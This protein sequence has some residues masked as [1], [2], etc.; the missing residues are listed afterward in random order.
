MEESFA[1]WLSP[2]NAGWRHRNG[3]FWVKVC[4]RS[5]HGVNPDKIISALPLKLT[6]AGPWHDRGD[7]TDKSSPSIYPERKTRRVRKQNAG[8]ASRGWIR[9]VLGGVEASGMAHP[10]VAR[11]AWKCVSMSLVFWVV[12]SFAIAALTTRFPLLRHCCHQ[13]P[14]SSTCSQCCFKAEG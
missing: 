6:R 11:D 13:S 1:N 5:R 7:G 3:C 10:S 4:T 14:C 9:R 8:K 2:A 12:P